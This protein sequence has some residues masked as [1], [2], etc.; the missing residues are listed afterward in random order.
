MQDF[1]TTLI[2][3]TDETVYTDPAYFSDLD[4]APALGVFAEVTDYVAGNVLVVIQI[5]PDKDNDSGWVDLSDVDAQYSDPSAY[6]ANGTNV[7]SAPNG[8]PAYRF[9]ITS[10]GGADMT[11]K[12]TALPRTQG[13][14]T[15]ITGPVTVDTEFGAAASTDDTSETSAPSL[16]KVYSYLRA[17]SGSA[18]Q[19]IRSGLSTVQSVVTGMLNTLP[20]GMYQSSPATLTNGQFAPLPLDSSQNLKVAMQNV[21]AVTQTG[22]LAGAGQV[23]GPYDVT[24]YKA[25]AFMLSG[26]FSL[27]W[28]AEH[29]V[30]GTDWESLPMH[31]ESQFQTIWQTGAA[32]ATSRQ[33]NT[34]LMTGYIRFRCS[35][36]VSG[37]ANGVVLL[38]PNAAVP[39][40]LNITGIINGAQAHDAA[41]VAANIPSLMAGYAS[42]QEPTPVS[43]TGD[44]VRSWYDRYGR[45]IVKRVENFTRITTATT[46]VVKS[47]QS[48]LHKIIIPQALTGAVT[49]YN[50]SSAAGAIL[51]TFAIGDKGVFEF[52][53][54]M[55]VGITVV[56]AAADQVIV[57][58]TD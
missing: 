38:F 12:I 37:S 14:V 47:V 56:T 9:K 19:S 54:A 22:T 2:I 21:A 39:N 55:G 41:A 18:W 46:T 33:L 20:Y 35:A 27:T 7:L 3:D 30:N 43:A 25:V 1:R 15:N 53:T 36:Y 40:T 51:A 26:T 16:V 4:V 17:W 8:F 45:G 50:N 44:V 6:S 29:S 24:A 52:D 28:I 13:G 42:N 31:Q 23:L 10:A 49:V 32:G 5:N 11:L 58:Y 34:S 48:E 57:T